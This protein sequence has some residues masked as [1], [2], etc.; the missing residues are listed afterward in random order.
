MIVAPTVHA[1]YGDRTGTNRSQSSADTTETAASELR[2]FAFVRQRDTSRPEAKLPTKVRLMHANTQEEEHASNSRVIHEIFRLVAVQRLNRDMITALKEARVAAASADP[3]SVPDERQTEKIAAELFTHWAI[4]AKNRP[5]AAAEQAALLPST[6]NKTRCAVVPDVDVGCS[7]VIDGLAHVIDGPDT[8]NWDNV[9]V[10][11][12]S[13]V[14][15]Q[16]WQY[17]Q[18]QTP[19][20]YEPDVLIPA[21]EEHRARGAAVPV[22]Q[23]CLAVTGNNKPLATQTALKITKL[24]NK[25]RCWL[26]DGITMFNA[27]QVEQS[28]WNSMNEMA[29]TVDGVRVKVGRRVVLTSERAEGGAAITVLR[30]G[31]VSLPILTRSLDKLRLLYWP[32]DVATAAGSPSAA[33]ELFLQRAFAML[34]RY[35]SLSGALDDCDRNSGM[36]A[37]VH[38]SFSLQLFAQFGV[39]TDAFANPLNATHPWFHSLFPDVDVWF[40]SLGSFFDAPQRVSAT[41]P[42]AMHVNPPFE[43][44]SIVRSAETMLQLLRQQCAPSTPRTF[45]MVIPDWGGAKLQP[46]IDGLK[47][48]PECVFVRL[49]SAHDS[50]YVDGHQHR[51]VCPFFKLGSKTLLMV[52]QNDAAKRS[53]PVE[54]PAETAL[55]GSLVYR[56]PDDHTRIA[57]VLGAWA[58]GSREV[59]QMAP[60]DARG[61][62][63]RPPPQGA[64]VEKSD[65]HS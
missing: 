32:S 61:D 47:N 37:S 29:I 7:V 20:R 34:L 55:D 3:G 52:L 24:A 6:G 9:L 33:E 28:P 1:T 38:P 39:D 10:R 49:I 51:L 59:L 26:A 2:R 40:G 31:E 16:S 65:I 62:R 13:T 27:S 8:T 36:H 46:V 22:F 21:P 25:W 30:C 41:L 18:L 54:G 14:T 63:K 45:V 19:A 12:G 64:R 50:V 43:T 11:A 15:S 56:T 53:C 57:A 4:Q 5:N 58:A 60:L 23:R 48:A 17:L 44:Q 42:F 35:H